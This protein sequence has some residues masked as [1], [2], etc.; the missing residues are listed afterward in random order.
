MQQFPMAC[1]T[2]F[3][4]LDFLH[5]YC[6]IHIWFA[7]FFFL[8]SY[9]SNCCILISS[10]IVFSFLDLSHSWCIVDV[11][12]ES[13]YIYSSFLNDCIL[14]SVFIFSSFL[15]WFNSWF[16]VHLVLKTVF[17]VFLTFICCFVYIHCFSSHNS[18]CSYSK[19]ITSQFHQT[20]SVSNHTHPFYSPVF[21]LTKSRSQITFII[22]NHT[23]TFVCI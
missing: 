10:F 6:L 20:V 5:S 23:H 18:S 8:D 2:V 7:I 21:F 12:P 17:F 15:D 4:L 14:I 16:I 22:F 13:L 9:F 1:L 19:C 11:F 3:I